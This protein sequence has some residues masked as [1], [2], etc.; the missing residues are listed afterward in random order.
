MFMSRLPTFTF[1]VLVVLIVNASLIFGKAAPQLQMV[2][3]GQGQ[4]RYFLPAGQTTELKIE[5]VNVAPV[6][7]YL[8]RGDALLDPNLKGSWAVIH[9]EDLGNFHLNYLE[10]AVWNFELEM[11]S[12]IQA[13]NATNALPQVV[14]VIQVTYLTSSGLQ[15]AEQGSFVVN[16]PGATV[17]QPN[18]L[19]W[20][21][22]VAVV[23]VLAASILAY[24]ASRK[25][26]D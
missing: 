16:V 23:I 11:P 3:I 22:V 2:M 13:A 9:S 21:V 25:H 18:P 15:Q 7:I 4:G 24:R 5:I 26:Q 10:S 8:I 19:T 20:V 17:V 14:L 6:D 1:V 12:K